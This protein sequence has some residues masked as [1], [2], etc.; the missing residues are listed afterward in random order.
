MKSHI[1][2]GLAALAVTT[3][4]L[5]A[6][7]LNLAG[8]GHTGYAAAIG[9][10]PKPNG[11]GSHGSSPKPHYGM[12]YYYDGST[13]MYTYLVATPLSSSSSYS[14][15]SLGTIYNTTTTDGSFGSTDI[16]DLTYSTSSLTNSGTEYVVVSAS[17]FLFNLQQLSPMYTSYNT[18]SNNE[19]FWDYVVSNASGYVTLTFV[20][21]EL[22][23]LDGVL[24][25]GV[26]IRFAGMAGGE[27]TTEP[28]EWGVDE[29]NNIVV[30]PGPTATYDGYL[31]F[32]GDSFTFNVDWGHST[33]YSF[34]GTLSDTELV[35]NRTGT[36]T[37]P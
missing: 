36:I 32:S 9:L 10:N 31:T 12:P 29:N 15:L 13:L 1:L 8:T 19:F 35:I 16:G 4:N 33:V 30:I 27:F 37:L 23:S 26:A 21:G 25:I 22:T 11:I 28:S 3:F 24:D 17:D 7:T 20:G 34:L 14:G 6:A 5:E 18:A 2:A